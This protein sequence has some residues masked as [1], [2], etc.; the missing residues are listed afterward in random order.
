MKVMGAAAWWEHARKCEW[1]AVAITRL[2]I[3]GAKRRATRQVNA[4]D[5]AYTESRS[6]CGSLLMLHSR[7]ESGQRPSD[8]EQTETEKRS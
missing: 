7:F 6:G 3:G 2:P 8:T 5:G 4:P 1:Q